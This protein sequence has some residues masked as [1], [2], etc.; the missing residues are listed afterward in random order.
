MQHIYVSPLFLKHYV[1]MQDQHL[2]NIT[3]LQCYSL[4]VLLWNLNFLKVVTGSELKNTCL[5][6]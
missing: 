5:I 1:A 3:F 2:R 6:Y 4:T